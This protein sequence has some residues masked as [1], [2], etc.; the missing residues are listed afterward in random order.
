MGLVEVNGPSLQMLQ[1]VKHVTTGKNYIRATKP[2]Q[3]IMYFCRIYIS[4][5]FY[6][7]LGLLANSKDHSCIDFEALHTFL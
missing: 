2:N 5:I 6:C 1:L 3:I 4:V 7:Y